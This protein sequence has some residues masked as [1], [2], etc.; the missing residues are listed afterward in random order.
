MTSKAHPNVRV[1]RGTYSP[2]GQRCWYLYDRRTRRHYQRYQIGTRVETRT[3]Q[4][5]CGAAT[6]I[7][8][9]AEAERLAILLSA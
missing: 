4:P 5:S 9:R 6:C 1:E 3:Y 2:T 7:W 8:T